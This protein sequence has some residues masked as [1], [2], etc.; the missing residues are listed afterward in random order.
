MLLLSRFQVALELRTAD[1][2][3]V[4]PLERLHPLV[5]RA[6]GR[7]CMRLRR[8]HEP[9]ESTKIALW[10]SRNVLPDLQGF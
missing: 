9:D 2:N 10:S 8:D 5:E 1:S 7:L 3:V 6:G 4:R